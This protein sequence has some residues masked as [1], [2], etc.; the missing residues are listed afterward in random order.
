MKESASIEITRIAK[1]LAAT[2]EKVFVLSIG[3]TH[4]GLPTIIKTRLKDS[5]DKNQTHYLEPMGLKELRNS[6]A[7]DEFNGS[8]QAEEII[9]VP[10]VK[11]GLYYYL[12]AFAGKKICVLEP[13]WLGYHAICSMCNKD[14]ARINIKQNNW[15]EQLAAT[16]FDALILC[17]PNNPDGKIYTEQEMQTVYSIVCQ[18]NA[19][20]IID[21]IYAKYS[22]EHNTKAILQPYYAKENVVVVNGFS[23]GYAATGLRLGY[24]AVHD[25]AVMKSMNLLHQNTATCANSISQFAFVDY[26]DAHDEVDAFASYYHTNRDLV[27]EII[28][29]LEAF[30][31]DGGFYFFIDLKVFGI[32]DAAKFCKD[33][34]QQEKI[35]LVPGSAYG[36]G[37][38]SW[39]RLSYSI[40]KDELL[41]G[42]KKFKQYLELYE[43]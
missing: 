10:G 14:I 31:P 19:C 34:L 20:L 23:K 28:P 36:E 4:F 24:V 5:L 12:D 6:I 38:D 32:E 25:K 41:E 8:Y 17:T 39:L 29:E 11:Q 30:K 9:V 37:F 1:Q 13:A 7:Q 16:S 3:D 35:A 40:D 42:I 27:C 15:M 2:G 26:K 22:F 21:E 43:R 33:I 18:N